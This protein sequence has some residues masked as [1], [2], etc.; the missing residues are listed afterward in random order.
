MRSGASLPQG[1]HIPALGAVAIVLPSR[2]SFFPIRASLRVVFSL[3]LLGAVFLILPSSTSRLLPREVARSPP[4]HPR[5]PDRGTVPPPS[6]KGGRELRPPPVNPCGTVSGDWSLVTSPT[7]D[8][9]VLEGAVHGHLGRRV[10][11]NIP[12]TQEEVLLPEPGKSRAQF[13]SD[14]EVPDHTP[15]PLPDQVQKYKQGHVAGCRGV[16]PPH[17][18]ARR[19]FVGW[20]ILTPAVY[21]AG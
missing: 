13:G 20:L 11:T 8:P 16:I 9:E 19:S 7:L 14:P 21:L 18:L 4:D 17:P 15:R 2:H 6:L 1:A 3:S 10:Y 12:F 5:P